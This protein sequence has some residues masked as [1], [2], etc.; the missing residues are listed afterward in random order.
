[1]KQEEKIELLK[2]RKEELKKF[3]VK[4]IHSCIASITKSMG[5]LY[6][7]GTYMH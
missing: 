6:R 1:M 4:K 3:G 2:S 7:G 5:T